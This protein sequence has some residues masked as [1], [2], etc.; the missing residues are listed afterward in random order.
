MGDG[1]RGV[2]ITASPVKSIALRLRAG[3]GGYGRQDEEKKGA[4][5]HHGGGVLVSRQALSAAGC[6][7]RAACCVLRAA[8]CLDPRRDSIFFIILC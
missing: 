1:L 8:C 7:L 4:G 3:A 2:H 6:V 5:H